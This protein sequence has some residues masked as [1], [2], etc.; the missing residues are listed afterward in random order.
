MRADPVSNK[1]ITGTLLVVAATEKEE[2]GLTIDIIGL[3]K[4]QVSAFNWGRGALPKGN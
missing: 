1:N 3:N 2:L 4:L